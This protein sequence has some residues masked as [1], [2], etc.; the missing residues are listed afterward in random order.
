[1]NKKVLWFI[2]FLVVAGLSCWATASSF[3]LI[4]PSLPW[5][6]IW[7]LTIVFFVFSSY[8]FK[9]IM[10]AVHNDGS[11]EHPKA[12]LWGGIALLLLTW[13]IISLPTNAH[14]FFYKLQI[15][16]QITQDLTTTEDYITQLARRDNL[17][18]TDSAQFYLLRNECQDLL[19]DFKNEA[20]GTGK[21][22]KLQN[23]NKF[24][25]H[26]INNINEKLGKMG[27][28]AMY[29][30]NITHNTI[31][32]KQEIEIASRSLNYQL[33]RIAD[34]KFKIKQETANK[35]AA[36]D[37][38]NLKTMHEVVD[39]II[40]AGK[41]SHP[42]SEHFIKQ[43]ESV[44]GKAY[45][46]INVNNDFVYFKTLDDEKLYTA[47]NLETRTSRFL[48]PYKV[49]G[50]FFIGKIPFIFIFWIILSILL[51]VLGFVSFDLALKKEF[52]Y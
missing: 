50:D 46:K 42:S 7:A 41:I 5:Y 9:M 10:D 28:F 12:K 3:M 22:T 8:A 15:K 40:Q 20:N 35:I 29:S 25:L 31:E 37:L 18:K 36:E 6:V 16:N 43:A 21:K 1:M 14:T 19:L 24:S 47:T 32:T 48:S 44:L 17:S 39:S 4:I 49:M 38:E 51:D 34:R 11:I 2:A 23:I 33:D 26:Y 27:D 30:P 45:S 13:V 52:D